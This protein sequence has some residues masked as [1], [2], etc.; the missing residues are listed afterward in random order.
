M[1][2][3]IH[4]SHD[5]SITPCFSLFRSPLSSTPGVLCL[6]LFASLTWMLFDTFE[7]WGGLVF[8]SGRIIPFYGYGACARRHFA[9]IL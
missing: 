6:E 7:A 1:H 9:Q 8:L 3:I 4:A 2:M 5:T